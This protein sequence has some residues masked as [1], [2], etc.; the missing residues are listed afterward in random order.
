MLWLNP[1][2]KETPRPLTDTHGEVKD[3]ESDVQPEEEDDVCHFA[4]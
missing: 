2:W 3:A 4:E 1:N